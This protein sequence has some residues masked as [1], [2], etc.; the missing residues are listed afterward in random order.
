ML[1]LLAALFLAADIYVVDDNGPADF[2]EI[3]PAIDA[4]K[5]GDTL[6]VRVGA[7]AGFTLTKRLTILGQDGP[8]EPFVG[9][10]PY[11]GGLVQIDGPVSFT[12]AG[13]RLS[14]VAVV[15]V[16]GSG[17]LDDLTVLNTVTVSNC[18]QLVISR[19][20][21][22]Q[23][24]T[25][26]AALA[27]GSSTLMLVDSDLT[28][29][30]GHSPFAGP[31]FPG[32]PALDAGT[33][34]LVVVAGSK[35]TGGDAG[36]GLFMD[37]KAGPALRCSFSTVIVRGSSFDVLDD[38]YVEPGFGGMPGS[39][40]DCA[41]GLVI[42]SGVTLAAPVSTSLGGTVIAAAAPEPYLEITGSDGL[43]AQRSLDLYGPAGTLGW[44]LLSTAPATFA[45]PKLELPLW[46]D[47]ASTLLV[48][49]LVMLGQD[50]PLSLTI[51]L[52]NTPGFAGITLRAQAV[53]P[54]LP[55]AWK[56]GQQTVSNLAPL[57]VRH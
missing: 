8:F 32:Q 27:V 39:A 24:T 4:A 25:D 28:G 18:P 33:N 49:P 29:G 53:Y 31:G 9:T 30:P 6:L 40:I 22:P 38:G 10:E 52:P 35:L 23:A 57:I 37:G 54:Q 17:L 14:T 20:V 5:A 2:S 48:A 51:T 26:F 3:Q 47:P 42:H 15:G 50:S 45:L 56:P 34:S 11:V 55:S 16:G 36:Q 46:L 21:M 41:G 13:M 43:G 44:L 19:L 12:L 1:A 7:Y